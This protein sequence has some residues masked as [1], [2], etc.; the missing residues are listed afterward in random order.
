[1]IPEEAA[2]EEEQEPRPVWPRLVAVLVLAGLLFA[3][4]MVWSDSDPFLD[5]EEDLA[6]AFD[7]RWERSSDPSWCADGCSATDHEWHTDESLA[8][9]RTAVTDIATA[10][11]LSTDYEAVGEEAAVMTLGDEIL[12]EVGITTPGW[13]RASPEAAGTAVWFTSVSFFDQ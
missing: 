8:E 6:A 13:S 1:M 2:T 5:M 11:G 3:A 7:E 4:V 9:V 10:I 12:L